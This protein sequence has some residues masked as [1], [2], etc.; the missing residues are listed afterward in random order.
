MRAPVPLLLDLRRFSWTLPGVVLQQLIGHDPASMARSVVH[1]RGCAGQIREATPKFQKPIEATI[2][3]PSVI[4][5]IRIPIP[6]SRN[7]EYEPL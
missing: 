4:R 7:K 2:E 3:T 1:H 6:P 5:K